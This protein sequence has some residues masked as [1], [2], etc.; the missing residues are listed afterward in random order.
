[1]HNRYLTEC[2]DQTGIGGEVDNLLDR[3]SGRSVESNEDS[4]NGA[5]TTNK[6][7]RED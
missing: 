7:E 2:H 1:M 6:D 3:F 4:K 5:K